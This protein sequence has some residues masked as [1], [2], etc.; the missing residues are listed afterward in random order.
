[1][2]EEMLLLAARVCL[3]AVFLYSGL[4]KLIC[5][6]NGLKFVNGLRLPQPQLVLSVT[7]VVQLVCGLS[8]LL[9]VRARE[10]AF[11]LAAF[12]VVATIIAHNPIGRR[13]EEFRRQC[14][15]SLEHLGIVGGLL[16]IATFGAGK[17]A[18][19]AL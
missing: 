13:G 1:M 14:M 12:T 11:L 16:L 7:I 17:F 3:S 18:I 5:W 8:V 6:Q 9:G 19:S 2:D 15:L 4:D 10:G